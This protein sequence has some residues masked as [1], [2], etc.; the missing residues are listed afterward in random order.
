[1]NY[2]VIVYRNNSKIKG[3]DHY[4][5]YNGNLTDDITEAELWNYK[6][7]AEKMLKSLKQNIE[8]SFKPRIAAVSITVKEI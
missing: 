5:M 8:G 4:L 3:E 1:M 6:P 2:H 7:D